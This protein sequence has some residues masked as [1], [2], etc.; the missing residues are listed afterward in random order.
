M[1]K[2]IFTMYLTFVVAIVSAQQQGAFRV[3]F[4]FGIAVPKGGAGLLAAI[5]PKYNI[6]DNMNVGLRLGSAILAKEIEYNT[7][8]EEVK[9]EVGVNAAMLL[10]YDYYL[11][12]GGRSAFYIGGGAG[13]FGLA[14]VKVDEENSPDEISTVGVNRKAGGMV[15]LGF[16]SGKFRMGVEYNLIPETE[17][18]NM[19]GTIV[20]TSRNS[21]AGMHMGFYFGGGKWGK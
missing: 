20:G 7:S 5:E 4:D 17:L 2:L 6:A 16:E 12:K 8:S 10:T 21:Y 15:R 18:Q 13:F 19:N 11:N 14:N 3:G 1:K 9:A